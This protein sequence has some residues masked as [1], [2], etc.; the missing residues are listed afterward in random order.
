M[1][2]YVGASCKKCRSLDTKLF[3][4]GT[5]CYTN[6]PFDKRKG[7]GPRKFRAKPSEY[8]IRLAEKRRTRHISGIMERPFSNLF[9]K[10]AR[11]KGKT[12][13]LFLRFL[14]TRLDNIVRRLGF[15]VSLKSARQLVL[16]GHVK[17]NNKTVNIPSHQVKVGN[18][19]KIDARLSD[20]VV[21]KSG[22]E[23]IEKRSA[24]ASFIEYDTDKLSGKLTRWPDREEMSYPVSEQLIV[25]YYSK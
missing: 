6:C 1:A 4:K 23:H 3:L 21:V 12:G 25:E 22:L 8:K 13:E 24:K 15:A 19:V 17:V 18:V 16:H 14:E 7:G 2:R 5:K 10:A 20:C 9:H 11:T